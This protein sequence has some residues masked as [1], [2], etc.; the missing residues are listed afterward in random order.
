VTS[1]GSAD[2]RTRCGVSRPAFIILAVLVAVLTV[3]RRLWKR[4]QVRDCDGAAQD[5][6]IV[7]FAAK[8]LAWTESDEE[9]Y[10]RACAIEEDR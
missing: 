3:S 7:V 4:R 5:I 10:R 8:D 9:W 1:S 6:L 2:D